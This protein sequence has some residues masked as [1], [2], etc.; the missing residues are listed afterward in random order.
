[1]SK[2]RMFF[3][4]W[5][6]FA[7][8]A[9]ASAQSSS[10]A[11]LFTATPLNDLGT[12]TYLGFEGGLYEDGSNVV[13]SDHN[14]AGL[15]LLSQIGPI[16]G[17]V[18]L[19]SLGMSNANYIF[20]SFQ[21]QA[22]ANNSVDHTSLA[23]VN[24]A[25]PNQVACFWTVAYGSPSSACPTAQGVSNEYDRVKTQLLTPA[26]LNENQVQVIW[27]YDADPSPK[28]SLPSSSADAYVLEGFFGGIARA[29]QTR[30]PNLRMMF[31]TSREYA[32]YATNTLNPEP[33]AYES[34]FAMKWLIQAQITQIRTGR[35]DAIAGDLDYNKG[36]APWI[37]WS[38]Y[39]WADG[40]HPRSD[41]LVW[42]DMQTGSPCYGDVD[43]A[44]DGTHPSTEG[45]LDLANLLLNYFLT[46]PY[47]G[48]WFLAPSK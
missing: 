29:A 42:C 31:I 35:I 14:Q 22:N 7:C 5:L 8:A 38:A 33:Y 12:G 2:G 11:P 40:P 23:I 39:T 18:V 20:M 47:S 37:V 28:I 25:E 19:L 26:H 16:N 45:A 21:Q 30:Y 24:G 41:G 32:G 9:A 36:V 3:A 44:P 15:S 1:M 6:F 48:S 17:K 10:V 13:P 43:V 46:S 4:C 34:G 27:V